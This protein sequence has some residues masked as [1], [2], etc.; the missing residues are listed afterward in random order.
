MIAISL[1]V[2]LYLVTSAKQSF[3]YE[4]YGSHKLE[5]DATGVIYP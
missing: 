5:Q 1:P 2:N 3:I 4:K